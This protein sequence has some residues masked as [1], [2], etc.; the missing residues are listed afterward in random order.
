MYHILIW[1]WYLANI[2]TSVNWQA[3]LLKHCGN[4]FYLVFLQRQHTVSQTHRL[5]CLLPGANQTKLL[6]LIKQDT[7]PKPIKNPCMRS[8][9]IFLKFFCV[10]VFEMNLILKL[11]YQTAKHSKYGYKWVT[12]LLSIFMIICL[13]GKQHW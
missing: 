1:I 7:S 6:S 3:I 9:E 2:E 12:S 11:S 4:C 10:T 13:Q 8:F 5:T